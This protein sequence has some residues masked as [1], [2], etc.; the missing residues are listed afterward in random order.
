MPGLRANLSG[1]GV[2]QDELKGAAYYWE[3]AARVLARA[4]L[5]PTVEI[6]QALLRLAQRWEKL[7]IKAATAEQTVQTLSSAENVAEL[8]IYRKANQLIRLHPSDADAV[9]ARLSRQ[10]YDRGDIFNFHL[11][12]RV[13]RAAMELGRK[14]SRGL[15]RN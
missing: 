7:A 10:A 6:R 1:G 4:D 15:V 9:A 11:W 5:A 12:T 8:E 2:E 3:Q 14:T 13:A